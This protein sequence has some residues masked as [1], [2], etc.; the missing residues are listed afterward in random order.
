VLTNILLNELVSALHGRAAMALG[1]AMGW[2]GDTTNA[3]IALSVQN[4]PHQRGKM[5]Q[6]VAVV[7]W[8]EGGLVPVLAEMHAGLI[9]GVIAVL[10]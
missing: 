8:V 3:E 10:F 5:L 4:F 6:R 7:G 9:V 2:P 1:I